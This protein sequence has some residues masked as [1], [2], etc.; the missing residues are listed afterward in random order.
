[1][2]QSNQIEIPPFYQGGIFLSP[3]KYSEYFGETSPDL[4]NIPILKVRSMI[5]GVRQNREKIHEFIKFLFI[6]ILKYNPENIVQPK[7]ISAEYS[8]PSMMGEKI[9]PLYLLKNHF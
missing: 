4:D 1:M 9:K 6:N 5:A 7:E 8:I 3:A 2:N